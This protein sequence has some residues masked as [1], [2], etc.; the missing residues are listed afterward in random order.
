[1]HDT[2]VKVQKTNTLSLLSYFIVPL[3]LHAHVSKSVTCEFPSHNRRF[4]YFSCF[5]LCDIP[6]RDSTLQY[7]STVFILS[8]S[9]AC[10]YL[11]IHDNIDAHQLHHLQHTRATFGVRTFPVHHQPVQFKSEFDSTT[12][13]NFLVMQSCG[14][15]FCPSSVTLPRPLQVGFI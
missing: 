10:C 14:N 3:S 1:M 5:F 6:L 2:G 4:S 7:V 11:L 8:P 15:S 13:R 9:C 12:G